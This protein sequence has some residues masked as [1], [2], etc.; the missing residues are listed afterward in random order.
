MKFLYN[1]QKPPCTTQKFSKISAAQPTQGLH[2]QKKGGCYRFGH[3]AAE[4]ARPVLALT[5]FTSAEATQGWYGAIV[6]AII[7]IKATKD[8]ARFSS[9]SGSISG[10][11]EGDEG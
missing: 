5:T 8:R 7:V 4:G 6:S 11:I 9:Q 3:E 2:G 10:D 1:N